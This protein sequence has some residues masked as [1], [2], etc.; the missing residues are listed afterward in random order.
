MV[1]TNTCIHNISIDEPLINH[2]ANIEN[3]RNRLFFLTQ[4]MIQTTIKTLNSDNTWNNGYKFTNTYHTNTNSFIH[5]F[6][7]FESVSV[8]TD[9]SNKHQ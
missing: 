3:F 8:I 6:P 9:N 1:I 2:C 5:S 4:Q 7:K